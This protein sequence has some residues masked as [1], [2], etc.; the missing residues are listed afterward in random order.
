MTLYVVANHVLTNQEK[1]DNVFFGTMISSHYIEEGKRTK[2]YYNLDARF[3]LEKVIN[4]IFHTK[5]P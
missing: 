4:V 3:E 5:L 2:Y 1:I